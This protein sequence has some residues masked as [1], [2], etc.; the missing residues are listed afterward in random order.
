MNSEFSPAPSSDVA[1]TTEQGSH[2][3]ETTQVD[4]YEPTDDGQG[5][6]GGQV[7]QEA[8]PTREDAFTSV[9]PDELPP[10]LQPLYKQLQGDYTRKTQSIAQM[11][12]ENE[13]KIQAYDQFQRD[14]VGTVQGVAAQ[15]GLTLT[16]AEAAQVANHAHQQGWTPQQGD[17]NSWDEPVNYAVQ[18]ARQ[19]ILS[20]I[21]PY[22]GQVQQVQ[23]VNI[24]KMLDESAPDWRHYEPQMMATLQAHPSLVNDPVLLYRMSVPPDVQESRATQAALKKLQAKTSAAR[25]SGISTSRHTTNAPDKAMSFEDAVQEARRQLNSKGISGPR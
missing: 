16:R 4:S 7:A 15:M 10:E 1:G 12:K 6:E 2:G 17:P 9:N 8:A 23:K 3:S 14:P 20:E 21:S 25:T 13:A 11:R 22:L 5:D 18:M 24:E 19:Q